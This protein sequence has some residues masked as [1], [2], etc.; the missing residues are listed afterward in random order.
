MSWELSKK[1]CV[2]Q[3]LLFVIVADVASASSRRDCCLDG[4]KM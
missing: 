3:E 4:F 2:N 1:Q